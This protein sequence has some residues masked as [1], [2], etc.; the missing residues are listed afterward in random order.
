MLAAFLIILRE[1]LEV[2]LIVS[3]ILAYLKKS[4]KSDLVIYLWTGVISALILS[5]ISGTVL[6]LFYGGLD[7]VAEKFFAGSVSVFASIV[8]TYMI[9]WMAKQARNIKET[10]EKRISTALTKGSYLSLFALSFTMVLR[11]G[12]ESVLFTT[13]LLINDLTGTLYGITLGMLVVLMFSF[14]LLK[15]VAYIDIGKFFKY[16]SII[17]IVVAA[18]ILG[19]GIHE[20]LEG[21]T[22]LGIDVGILSMELFNINPPQNPDGSYPLLHEKGLVGSF[23]KTLVGYDGNPEILRV[24]IY[25]IYWVVLGVYFLKDRSHPKS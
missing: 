1:G 21:F 25:V 20:F 14:A 12:I 11:E 3:L 4:N 8:L 6:Y 10:F 19:Y 22:L 23:L 17:L 16:T 13:S 5:V 24:I 2:A 15:G 18:G 9:L 7:E